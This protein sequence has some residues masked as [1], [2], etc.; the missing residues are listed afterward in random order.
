MAGTFQS[1]VPKARCQIPAGR[2]VPEL[3]RASTIP[4][5]GNDAPTFRWR[6]KK[7][8]I[9][10]QILTAQFTARDRANVGS[11]RRMWP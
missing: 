5:R 1:M 11:E 7:S 2:P 6:R 8:E 9:R 4:H 10:H 3:A